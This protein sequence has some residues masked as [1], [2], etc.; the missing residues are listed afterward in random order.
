MAEKTQ[1]TPNGS[2]SSGELEARKLINPRVEIDTSPPFGSVK[3]AV[4]RFGG[5]GSWIPLH[6]LRLAGVSLLFTFLFIFHYLKMFICLLCS[7]MTIICFKGVWN[8]L[9]K[10]K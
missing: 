9:S 8:Y 6:I 2:V 5:S 1:Q 10:V 7:Y 4:T 3:E